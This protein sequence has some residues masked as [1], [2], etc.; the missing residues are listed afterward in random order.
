MSKRVAFSN[1][2]SAPIRAAYSLYADAYRPRLEPVA[3]R[4]GYKT[5]M[6]F[7]SNYGKNMVIHQNIMANHHIYGI[8]TISPF[9]WSIL[10]TIVRS[11]QQFETLCLFNHVQPVRNSISAPIRAAYSLYADAHSPR[12][13][14][15]LSYSLLPTSHSYAA[16]QGDAFQPRA[17]NLVSIVKQ[18]VKSNCREGGA[19]PVAVLK[20]Y[21]GRA[22]TIHIKAHGAGPERVIGEGDVDWKAVFAFCE[23]KG[24]TQWYVVEHETSKDRL[25]A[26]KRNFEALKKMGKV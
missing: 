19:D 8:L 22:Q 26:V 18:L 5:L 4:L 15:N 3:D 13:E 21:P 9:S 7:L 1:S 24:K 6:N 20:K 12:L 11:Y 2:I 23:G 14:P 10:R 17:G 16:A 25:D